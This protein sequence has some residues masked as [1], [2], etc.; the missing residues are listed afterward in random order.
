MK[1]KQE[2]TRHKKRA[3]RRRKQEGGKEGSA[4]RKRECTRRA[5]IPPPP[6]PLIKNVHIL[7]RRTLRKPFSGPEM[8]PSSTRSEADR[9]RPEMDWARSRP[10]QR[11]RL[12]E[13]GFS[14]PSGKE[15]GVWDKNS[16]F[17]PQQRSQRYRLVITGLIAPASRYS[18][19]EIL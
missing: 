15:G 8:T 4:R 6:P 5:E 12:K 18:S 13:D 14:E 9:R 10:P 7:K 3:R 1:N 17:F 16:I 2:D 11:P 19:I